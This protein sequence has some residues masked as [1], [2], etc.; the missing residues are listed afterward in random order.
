MALT[1]VHIY[2]NALKPQKC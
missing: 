2:T 1:K